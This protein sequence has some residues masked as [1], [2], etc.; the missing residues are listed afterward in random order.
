MALQLDSE[1]PDAF[2]VT[3]DHRF[4]NFFLQSRVISELFR[5]CITQELGTCIPDKLAGKVI[6]RM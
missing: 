5:E 4:F 3:E 6:P 2:L 1:T